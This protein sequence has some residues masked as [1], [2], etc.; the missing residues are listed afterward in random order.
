MSEHCLGLNSRY[1]INEMCWVALETKILLIILY[2]V[3]ALSKSV[4]I[5][6]YSLIVGVGKG[7]VLWVGEVTKIIIKLS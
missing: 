2:P 6:L 3:L 4:L 7:G 5:S 1:H